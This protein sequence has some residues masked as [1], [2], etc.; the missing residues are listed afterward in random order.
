MDFYKMKQAIVP[1]L[2]FEKPTTQ[3]TILKIDDKAFTYSIGENGRSKKIRFDVLET[4]F[5]QLESTRILSRSWFN[6]TFP[7]IAKSAPCSFTTIGGLFQH[8]GFA[9]YQKPAYIKKEV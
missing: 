7:S 8:F 1:G 3:S 5:H 4:C 6:T 2:T 9:T